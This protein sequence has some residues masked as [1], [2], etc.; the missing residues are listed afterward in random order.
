M[1]ITNIYG[2]EL[3][4]IPLKK[5]IL[6]KITEQKKITQGILRPKPKPKVKIEANK[7]SKEIIQ[8]KSKPSGK[9]DDKETQN[10]V[11]TKKE[12]KEKTLQV[13]E[14]KKTK[15]D[16]LIPK[17]KPLV[18]KKST[19]NIKIKSKYYSQ[20]DFDIA[21]KSIKA[22]ENRKWS[23]ALSISKKA[24]D[25]SIYDFIQW[26]HLLTKG[27][28][29]SF[30]DYNTFIKKNENYP[31]INRIRYLAEH[32]LSTEK[33]SP[34]KIIDWFGLNDPLSGFGK[35]ILGESLILK[36]DIN[37]GISLIKEGWITA[38][39][40][41]S[42]MKFFR[43]KYKKYLDSNDYIKRADYLAWESKHWDLKRM[44][45][46]LPKDY[47]LLYTARQILMSKSYGVDKAIADVPAKLKN[48]PGLNY[49][50]LKWRRKRG[51]VESSLEILQ[52]IKNTK[53]YMIRP[54]KWWKERSII[55]RSLIYKKKY[56]TAYKISSKHALESGPEFA[57][58]EWMS[59]WIALSFLNDPI[60]AI[61]HFNNFYQ[62]VGY[63]ISLSRGAYWLGRSYEQIGDKN[64]SQEWYEEATKYLTTYYGQLAHLKIKP[65]EKFE[66]EEQQ[67]VNDEY[68]KY[69]YKIDLVKIVYL[70]NELNK[71]KY[72]KH[73]LRYLA[74]DNIDNGSEILAAELSTN[75]S[76]YD[77][78]IQ[79]S[80]LASYQKRFHND[81][82][83]PIISTPKYINGRKIPETAFIL[84]IIRQESE[85]DMK[86]NS[87]VGAQGLMQL[88]PYTAKLVAKQAKLPY[89]KSRLT[90]D[91]EYNINLGS[92][93]IAGLILQYEGAYPF[94]TAAY[95]AGPKRV[96]YWKKLNKDPQKK[97]TNYVD[98]I[99]LIKFKETRNYVQRVLE[100]YNVYRYI[101]E[102]KPIEM[103]DF[104]K[105]QPL[106]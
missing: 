74:N 12:T 103:K 37:K 34:K 11:K 18:V 26:R 81:F 48:D 66:L 10:I 105:D 33:V 50:R 35:L 22:M 4:I 32:K 8:P 89:S 53:E 7:L 41:R 72:T 49:D 59:G 86:A 94:A 42:E 17:S 70:L 55:A 87:R 85:F 101:L 62:N 15:I 16:F 61:D 93:Y 19:S 13:V 24:K 31:R 84:S 57:E 6:D 2:Q 39:L 67:K 95:N 90:S 69:F 40:S 54:D 91:P 68:K 92:H 98:W 104:F 25:K 44:L 76:R 36:G 60:L 73:I 63:P 102:K 65:N 100:N 1:F 51:R 43:K 14:K 47:Q 21:K 3:T 77:F 71:D 29:A 106:F 27:N 58:A 5:P 79:I 78:A 88:M 82:N 99:E 96:K 30:Y 83:Y 9:N 46:Y 38:D 80:K 52:K 23:T 64:K 56:E 20:R 28:Q 97:Q 75:I 45:R